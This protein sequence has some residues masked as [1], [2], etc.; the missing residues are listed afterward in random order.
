[1]SVHSCAL[2]EAALRGEERAI[3]NGSHGEHPTYDGTCSV[4]VVRTDQIKKDTRKG[5]VRCQEVRERLA[6]LAMCNED[7]R[8]F[9]TEEDACDG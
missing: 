3:K 2:L 8:D 1:M 7:G 4:V 6:R 5:G 9:I